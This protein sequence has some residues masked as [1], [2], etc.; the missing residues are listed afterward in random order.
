MD[1]RA[2][3]T[4]LIEGLREQLAV[5]QAS[6]ADAASSATHE[7]AKPENQYDTRGLEASYL[8]GAQAGRAADLERR[9]SALSQ[10]ELQSY[11][12]ADRIALCALITLEDEEGGQR[13]LLIAPEG[14]GVKLASPEGPVVVVSPSAP[15]ARALIGKSVGDEISLR[16]QQLEIIGLS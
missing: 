11:S 16:G 7:E 2:L 14:G 5:V 1:K 3:F 10:L 15:L 12:G 13:R 4:Q 6:A 9:I 8:A